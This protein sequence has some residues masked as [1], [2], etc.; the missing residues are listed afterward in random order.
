MTENDLGPQA[1]NM[2]TSNKIDL[3]IL[4]QSAKSIIKRYEEIAEEQNPLKHYNLK[5]R[6]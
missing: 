6:N 1:R 4:R 2:P 5:K 3:N